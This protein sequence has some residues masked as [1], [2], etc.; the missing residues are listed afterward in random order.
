MSAE[1]VAHGVIHIN[2]QTKFQP[3]TSAADAPVATSHTPSTSAP[4]E[5]V[6]QHKTTAEIEAEAAQQAIDLAAANSKASS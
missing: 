2:V 1:Q 6:V 3:E 5:P 4:P